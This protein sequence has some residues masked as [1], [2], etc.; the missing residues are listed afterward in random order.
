MRLREGVPANHERVYRLYCQEGLAM[1]TRQRRRICW[2][3]A[4]VETAASQPN[5]RWSMDFVSDME[6][7]RQHSRFKSYLLRSGRRGVVMLL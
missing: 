6:I 7:P 1:R 4:V 3:G 2:N 5:E